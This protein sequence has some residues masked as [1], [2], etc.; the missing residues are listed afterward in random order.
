MAGHKSVAMIEEHYGH[1]CEQHQD[2]AVDVVSEAVSRL[3]VKADSDSM[4]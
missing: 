3:A 1:V 4:G 2:E